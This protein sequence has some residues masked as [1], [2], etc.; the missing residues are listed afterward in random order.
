MS[1]IE[2]V[3]VVAAAKICGVSIP[4]FHA[5]VKRGKVPAPINSEPRRLRWDRA[6][7]IA[8]A[9]IMRA[10]RERA[11]ES[12]RAAKLVPRTRLENG[13]A[14][15]AS[16]MPLDPMFEHARAHITYAVSEI[17]HS[18]H[19]RAYSVPAQQRLFDMFFHLRWP[20]CRG[21]SMFKRSSR[22]IYA[23]DKKIP[24]EFDH[25]TI[26]R[27][28]KNFALITSEPYSA[29][30]E[31]LASM[32]EWAAGRGFQAEFPIFPS[33]WYPGNTTLCLFFNQ[34]SIDALIRDALAQ[35]DERDR[36]R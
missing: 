10:K 1:E 23:L 2:L 13:R 4:A 3:G 9:E 5:A 15:L 16:P 31:Q 25:V 12:A 33:P 26:W 22:S 30:E 11:K 36:G 32:T 20:E 27:I 24:Q 6:E 14:I 19:A 18:I 21:I 7:I 35:P 8:A 28:K 29:T 34:R 17:I